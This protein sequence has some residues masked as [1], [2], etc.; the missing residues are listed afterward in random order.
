MRFEKVD[1][2]YYCGIGLHFRSIYISIMDKEGEAL[3]P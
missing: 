2:E 1:T 3:S